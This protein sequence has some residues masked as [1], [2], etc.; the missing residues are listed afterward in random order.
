MTLYKTTFSKHRGYE[1]PKTIDY[2]PIVSALYK[3]EQDI[4]LKD[5]V[6]SK[7]IGTAMKIEDLSKYEEFLDNRTVL[8]YSRHNSTN[9]LVDIYT[10]E[11]LQVIS[12]G[13]G[14][15]LRKDNIYSIYLITYINDTIIIY[16]YDQQNRT[17]MEL[18]SIE[19]ED[20][21]TYYIYKNRYIILESEP[22]IV[23][24]Y[25]LENNNQMV[26]QLEIEGEL[27]TFEDDPNR[28][29]YVNTDGVHFISFSDTL[30]IV[31]G[32]KIKMN[33]SSVGDSFCA[34]NKFFFLKDDT[35]Y[36]I[37][38][39]TLSIINIYFDGNVIDQAKAKLEKGILPS[40]GDVTYLEY[41][42]GDNILIQG[43]EH[44]SE[45]QFEEEEDEDENLYD[46]NGDPL[47]EDTIEMMRERRREENQEEK[48]KS[49]IYNFRTGK[50]EIL[51]DII[52]KITM[53]ND[54]FCILDTKLFDLQSYRYKF[55]NMVF[56]LYMP[57]RLDSQIKD[58]LQLITSLFKNTSLINN[59]IK[60]LIARFI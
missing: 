26:K 41:L 39:S 23:S 32:N 58:M 34:K 33:T 53:I 40:L 59:N 28:F 13:E 37:D 43:G 8:E 27:L 38:I 50:Q 25:D 46:E 21:N 29:Y 57:Y 56:D 15:N 4:Y 16:R 9:S 6:T 31:E 11:V 44:K 45:E 35:L 55:T 52:Y 5:I 54:N 18:P 60:R 36:M 48:D 17:L 19:L 7:E 22:N 2:N 47:D 14:A 10:G 12:I 51:D 1:R 49:K 3:N 24:F 20:V 42:G 30:D